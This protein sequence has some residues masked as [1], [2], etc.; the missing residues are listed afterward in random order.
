MP[1]LIPLHI[2]QISYVYVRPV[3]TIEQNYAVGTV[4]MQLVYQPQQVGYIL[5]QFHYY[6]YAYACLYPP[7]D[8]NITL[9]RHPIG[10]IFIGRNKHYVQ[11][12]RISAGFFYLPREIFPFIR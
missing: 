5:S 4:C 10:Q 12:Y 6:R 2:F 8:F 7:E 11:F 1:E 9:L 3:H